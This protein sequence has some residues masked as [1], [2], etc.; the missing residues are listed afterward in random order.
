MKV[1]T[2]YFYVFSNLFTISIYYFYNQ[3]K[4]KYRTM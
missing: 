1:Y 2:L 4:I 3:K